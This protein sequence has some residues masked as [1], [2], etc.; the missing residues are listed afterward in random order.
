LDSL[1]LLLFSSFGDLDLDRDLEPALEAD[2]DFAFG[3]RDL[4]FDRDLDLSLGDRDLDLD[5]DRD[6]SLGDL[7]FP[8]GDRDLER[9]ADLSLADPERDLALR[10]PERERDL[11]LRD[12]DL[13][14]VLL[15]L[16]V[17][18]RFPPAPRLSST[19]LILRPLS[20][21]SSSLDNA[22]FMSS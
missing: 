7:D 2:R 9:L 19:S 13:L 8:L 11:S 15:R 16:L 6:L 10:E 18:L 5:L 1:L 4:S 20:S 17:P 14:L 3:D 21:M 22:C 12:R